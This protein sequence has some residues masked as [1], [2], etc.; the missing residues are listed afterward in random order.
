MGENCN[1]SHAA[2][3][4]EGDLVLCGHDNSGARPDG[5]K[6]GD[7]H[8][9]TCAT[10]CAANQHLHQHDD[11]LGPYLC[12]R[13]APKD[14]TTYDDD[15]VPGEGDRWEYDN[16]NK[17]DHLWV[18]HDPRRSD[19]DTT[20]KDDFVEKDLS[21]RDPDYRH[22]N[23]KDSVVLGRER[24]KPQTSYDAEFVGK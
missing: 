6:L 8:Y 18:M 21:E 14:G 1:E 3:P 17:P 9:Q 23:T 4:G 2:I 13:H 19:W 12:S 22:K 10:P 15:F 7:D 24:Y 11:L 20:N 16:R 5:G